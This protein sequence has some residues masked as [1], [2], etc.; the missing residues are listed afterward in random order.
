MAAGIGVAML[1][2]PERAVAGIANSKHDLSSG[3]S[4]TAQGKSSTISEI[5]VFCHTPHGSD[6]S[7]AVPLWNKA[8][9]AGNTFTTYKAL[10]TST[11]DA[12]QGV[13]GSVSLAC[14]SC[15]D[16]AQ[17][18]D[19]MINAPGSGGYTAGGSTGT[20]ALK[21]TGDPIPKIGKDLQNDHPISMP[22]AG[23]LASGN[24]TTAT[25]TGFK[26]ADFHPVVGKNINGN[27]VW[28]VDTAGGTAGSRDK[29][30]MV[31]YTRAAG[32]PNVDGTTLAAATPFVE[33]ASCHDPHQGSNA[34]FLRIPNTAS[35]VCLACHNK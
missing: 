3:S 24:W 6:T 31:L 8:L 15:H 33:C 23:G 18:M 21:M 11:Y 9:P 16:G 13:V 4:A 30:D 25:T 28:W 26:D 2:N 19:S 22:Y 34:T 14:L 32:S 5:C 27:D 35:A 10:N 20:A 17:A 12:T 1:A 29:T 7:A